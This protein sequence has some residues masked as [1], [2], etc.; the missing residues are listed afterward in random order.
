MDSPRNKKITDLEETMKCMM[1]ERDQLRR[2]SLYLQQDRERII[3]EDAEKIRNLEAQIA[4]N[5]NKLEEIANRNQYLELEFNN[6]NKEKEQKIITR[7]DFIH[8]LD[9]GKA[10]ELETEI[11]V[12]KTKNTLLQE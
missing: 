7:E 4:L 3:R 1:Q 5:I 10:D 2:E 8:N 11:N 9:L 6:V 12:L